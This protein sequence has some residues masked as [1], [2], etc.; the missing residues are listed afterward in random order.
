[1]AGSDEHYLKPLE[2]ASKNRPRQAPLDHDQIKFLLIGGD[3]PV[4]N[5]DVNPSMIIGLCQLCE[6]KLGILDIRKWSK[7][8]S[9]IALM[10]IHT[11]LLDPNYNHRDEAQDEFTTFDR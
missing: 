7:R 10:I 11:M 1:M 4:D 8:S 2:R 9:E 5:P 6:I 3:P